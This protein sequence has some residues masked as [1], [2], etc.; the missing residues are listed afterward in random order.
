M[1]A[2]YPSR[3]RE[4]ERHKNRQIAYGRWQP[5]VSAA[6]ARAHVLHL[7]SQGMGPVTIARVSGVPHGSVS[8]LVYG[9]YARN[10]A[11]SKR[12]RSATEAALLAVQPALENLSGAALVDG[13]GTRRRL[14]ALVAIGWSQSELGRRI[15]M[16]PQSIQK[17]LRGDRVYARTARKVLALYDELSMTPGP[18]GRARRL[19]AAKKWP[20][21][22]AWD[23]DEID[24]LDGEPA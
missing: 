8:K 6:R 5:Y 3:T 23:D 21:P 11:P 2:P 13:T 1:T 18:S 20:P 24:L 22:L 4:Y 12:I 14:Q 9:D 19:A 10:M 16:A 17:T 7:M 15:G